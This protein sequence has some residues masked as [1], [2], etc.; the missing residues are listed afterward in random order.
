MTLTRPEAAER[1]FDEQHRTITVGLLALV[2]M[3]AFEAVAVSLAMPS[4]ARDLGGETL[5][6]IAVIGMLTAA[7]VGMVV[8]GIWGDA[9]GAALPVTVGGLGFVA[10][11][12]VSGFA[13]SMEV[14]VGGRLLQGLGGG[15]AL[16]AL[17]VAVADA[18]PPRLRTRVF[19]L[20]ATAW[21]VPSIAGPF[22]AGALVDLFGWRSVF[23]VVAAFAAFS[24]LA[25][26]RP[27]SRHLVVRHQP[28]VWG[29][30]PLYAV[31]AAT[32]VVAL[33]LAGHGSG[34]RSALLLLAG[35]LVVAVATGPLLPRGTTRA[36]RGLP[37]VIASRGLFGA[38]FA[39][40]EIFLPLVLQVETG[41][42]PTLS[43]LVMMVGALGWVAGSAYSGK[44]AQPETFPRIMRV[45]SLSLLVGTLVIMGLVPID[46]RP[47]L[48][49]VVAT[50]GILVMAIGMGLST[51]LMSTLALDLAPEGRQGDTGAAIQMSD[52]LGQSIAAGIVG[53]VF[54]R[55]F[56]IDAHTS[57]LAGFGMAL[58]LALVATVTARRSTQDA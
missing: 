30:R 35:L 46:H 53:A 16:T 37:A 3:F 17:Y 33:H 58:L 32:G 57:Y 20:F 52:S 1:A 14:L 2:T 54:A 31:I 19:S 51:P 47:V 26:R 34:I 12:L 5:Y 55:W 25:V 40:V 27:M 42:S 41:M 29:R 23:L 39:C 11:L 22:V 24:V 7:I 49:P 45:G 9:R 21:V 38:A 13:G 10:G 43:G 15:A 48:A 44:H 28:V 8:G 18:Y 50:V 36:T 6:P 56:L 4:V